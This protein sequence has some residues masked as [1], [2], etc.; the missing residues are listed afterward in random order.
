MAMTVKEVRKWLDQFQPEEF[1][2]INDD[3]MALVDEDN[4]R[5]YLEIGGIRIVF[6]CGGCGAQVF[7][8][9]Y[10]TVRDPD[11]ELEPGPWH[12]DD[13]D[14]RAVKIKEEA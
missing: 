13:E 9:D 12:F 5:N 7:R 14:C 10:R 8:R 2:A 3:G 1:I 11:F 4:D 6:D